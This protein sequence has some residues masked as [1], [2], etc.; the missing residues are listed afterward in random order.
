MLLHEV[1]QQRCLQNAKSSSCEIDN[2]LL[3]YHLSDGQNSKLETDTQTTSASCVSKHR[4]LARESVH[5][6][7][8][9]RRV[10]LFRQGDI[11]EIPLEKLRNTICSGGRRQCAASTTT[12]SDSVHRQTHQKG[13]KSLDRPSTYNLH[14]WIHLNEYEWISMNDAWFIISS[15]YDL[16]YK[17]TLER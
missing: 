7:V 8:T 2:I 14:Q 1:N 16:R 15:Y 5:C 9:Q 17:T 6:P 10:C 13:R 4:T 3:R 11:V 12:Q